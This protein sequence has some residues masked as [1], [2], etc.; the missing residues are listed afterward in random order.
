VSL[1]DTVLD[2]DY[3]NCYH[4]G[5]LGTDSPLFTAAQIVLNK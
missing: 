3:E 5:Q 1:N 4:I 2:S